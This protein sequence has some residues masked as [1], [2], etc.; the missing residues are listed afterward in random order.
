MKGDLS[1]YSKR[2]KSTERMLFIALLFFIAIGA[3][4]AI[5]CHENDIGRSWSRDILEVARFVPAR[6]WALYASYGDE[7]AIYYFFTW[8]VL[9][10][11]TAWIIARFAFPLPSGFSSGGRVPNSLMTII[12]IPMLAL[13]GFLILLGK[14]GADLRFLRIGTR[15]DHLILF[16]WFSF[17]MSG[18]LFGVC[19]LYCYKA[20]MDIRG[21]VRR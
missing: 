5:A 4:A 10:L 19:T 18:V 9:P 12:A 13:V 21:L 8:P 6:R 17:A 20:F 14:D 16:G 15:F 1:R 7:A 3:I 11:A 2:A